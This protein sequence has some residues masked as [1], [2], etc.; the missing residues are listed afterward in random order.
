M[1]SF[2]LGS[3]SERSERGSWRSQLWVAMRVDCRKGRPGKIPPRSMSDFPG[4]RREAPAGPGPETHSK[5][6]LEAVPGSKEP[7]EHRPLEPTGAL[8]VAR[9]APE[10]PPVRSRAGP[11]DQEGRGGSQT[12]GNPLHRS[13]QP[14]QIL[15]EPVS[16]ASVA[17]AAGHYTR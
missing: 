2:T 1:A 8:Q 13:R 5:R 7:R 11:A 14:K 15:S 9:E 4:Q 6:S 3:L 10:T 17:L 12:V 16:A